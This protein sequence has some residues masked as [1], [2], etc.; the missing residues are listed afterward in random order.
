MGKDEGCSACRTSRCL[1]GQQAV[2]NRDLDLKREAEHGDAA[3]G[4]THSEALVHTTGVSPTT[5]REPGEEK[6]PREL[7][8]G[9]RCKNLANR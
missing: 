9:Q 6:E 3:L 5:S 4:G 8:D 1:R 7:R 2:G